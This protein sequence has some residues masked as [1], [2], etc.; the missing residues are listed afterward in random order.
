MLPLLMLAQNKIKD[1]FALLP[2]N[3]PLNA[4]R[5][6]A[7]ELFW[8]NH[9]DQK[10]K[11]FCLQGDKRTVSCLPFW[12]GGLACHLDLLSLFQGHKKCFQVSDIVRQIEV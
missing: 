8:G 10:A 9:R 2:V 4:C 5:S 6:F 12:H 1:L 7:S 3:L 11:I